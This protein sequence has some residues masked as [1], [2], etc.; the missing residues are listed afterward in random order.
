MESM[1]WERVG[2]LADRAPRISDL[3]HHKLHLLAASRM[4]A[5]GEVV[6]SE[7]REDEWVAVAIELA[8]GTLIKHVRAAT[9]APILVM[10]GPE[11]ARLWPHPR[12]RPWN[13]LDLLVEDADAVQDALLAAGFVEVGDPR[14]YENI[15]HLRPLALP[16]SPLS[17]EVH[18]HPKWPSENPPQFEDLADAAVGGYFTVPG[19]L[20]PSPAHHA[21]LLAAHAWEH[22]PLSRL[23][24]LADI[25]AMAIAGGPDN[26]AQ[27]A[28]AWG[29]GRVWS[30]TWRAIDDVLLHPSGSLRRPI[31]RRHLHEARERTVLEAHIERV[32]GPAAGTSLAAA[33]VATTK[34]ALQTLR[35]TPDEGWGSKL[36]RSGRAVRNASLRRS[37]HAQEVETS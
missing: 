2:E 31:W 8:T 34:A 27:I 11:A 4:R 37:D 24:Q 14:L 22:D 3:R 9:D 6:P 30:A 32:V 7:L 1:L 16:W 26:A 33:P 13:D 35:P 29:V 18:M 21:V 23:G 25:A 19:V 17:I 36:R 10:K 15:H 28:R 20:T 12:L 5:R